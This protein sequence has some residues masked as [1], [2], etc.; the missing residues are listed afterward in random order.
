MEIRVYMDALEALE[1]EIKG[2]TKKETMSPTEVS[3][4]KEALCAAKSIMDIIGELPK[5]AGDNA[6]N[7]Y[8]SSYA[9]RPGFKHESEYSGAYFPREVYSGYPYSYRRGRSATTGRYVSRGEHGTSYGDDY[10]GHSINDRMVA[11]MEDMYDEAK[12][13]HERQK[14]DTAI[15]MIRQ[16][17]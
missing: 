1:R 11:A 8:S 14:I 9:V 4:M 13:D 15:R 10:S 17:N 3:N 2:I 6:S 12:T 16:N 5:D 7:G